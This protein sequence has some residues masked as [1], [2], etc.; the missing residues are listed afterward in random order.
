MSDLFEA[1]I[2]V[3]F[4]TSNKTDIVRKIRCN[5]NSQIKMTI[6]EY[7]KANNINLKKYYIYYNQTQIDE[8]KK[9]NEYGIKSGDNL[10]TSNKKLTFN[11]NYNNTFYSKSTDDIMNAS[12]NEN[13]PQYFIEKKSHFCYKCMKIIS[14]L[15]IVI[16]L[17]FICIFLF[18]IWKKNH[19]NN[20]RPINIFVNSTDAPSFIP[21]ETNSEIIHTST[22][23]IKSSLLNNQS[24]IPTNIPNV[25][26]SILYTQS[27]IP[28]TIPN[29]QSSALNNQSIIPINISNIQSSTLNTQSKIPATIPNMQ[30]SMLNTQTIIS[31]TYPNIQSSILNNQSIISTTIPNIQSSILNTQSTIST[32]Y[33]NIQSSILNS[34]SILISLPEST[35]AS[36]PLS[37]IDDIAITE[38]LVPEEKLAV[39]LNYK[40]NETMIFTQ[41]KINNSTQ[42]INDKQYNNITRSF[43]NFSVT[44]A[45]EFLEDNKKA[46]S[47]YLVILNMTNYKDNS[48]ELVANFDIFNNY[49]NVEIRNLNETIEK[50][51]DN[52]NEEEIINLSGKNFEDNNISEIYKIY[53]DKFNCSVDNESNSECDNLINSFQTFPVV[54]FTFFRNGEIKD[55]LLPKYLKSTIFFNM[56][57]LI[58]KIIPKINKD[59]YNKKKDKFWGLE[60]DEEITTYREIENFSDDGKQ[61]NLVEVEKSKVYADESS[62]EIKFEGSTSNS[63][64]I[65]KYNS[66][67]QMIENIN[68]KGKIALINDLPDEEDSTESNLLNNGIKSINLYTE[69]DIT[70]NKNII[71]S[72]IIDCLDDIF[73]KMEIIKYNESKYG[74]NTIRLLNSLSNNNVTVMKRD[75]NKIWSKIKLY[76]NKKAAHKELEMLRKLSSEA[77]MEFSY[78]Y[79]IFKTNIFGLKLQLQAIETFNV[80]KGKMQIQIILTVGC[81]DISYPITCFDSNINEIMKNT[82]TNTEKLI[83]L[84]NEANIINENLSHNFSNII[85]NYEEN[86]T[87]L[88]KDPFDFYNLYSKSLNDLYYSVENLTVD[89]LFD[90]IDLITICHDNYT[91]LLNRTKN[92]EEISINEIREVIINEY[93]SFINKMMEHLESFYNS[94]LIFLE[95]I[96]GLLTDN[97][98][99]DILYDIKDIIISTNNI[100]TKFGNLLFSSIQK[101]MEEFNY[102]LKNYI[103]SILGVL[104]ENSQFIAN[105]L[106]ENAI[107]RK[108]LSS[109]KREAIMT[110]LKNFKII[111]NEVVNYLYYKINDDYIINFENESKTNIKNIVKD[112]VLNYEMKFNEESGT[113]LSKIIRLINDIENYELYASNLN[114]IYNAGNNISESMFQGIYDDIMK[115]S[116]NKLNFV[117]SKELL[118]NKTIEIIDFINNDIKNINNYIHDYSFDYK[119][120]N[121]YKILSNLTRVNKYFKKSEM[122]NLMNEFYNLIKYSANKT[123]TETL[124]YNYN[125]SL[126]YLQS[127]YDYLWEKRNKDAKGVTYRFLDTTSNFVSN[128]ANLLSQIISE[129]P[130]MVKK[131]FLEI[132]NDIFKYFENKLSKIKKLNLNYTI[133]DDFIDLLNEEINT[134]KDNIKDY[135]NEEVFEREFLMNINNFTNE[136]AI[137][138]SDEYSKTY[139]TLYNKIMNLNDYPKA[140]SADSYHMWIVN[141][142]GIKTHR[143]MTQTS[144]YYSDMQKTFKNI[145]HINDFLE[146]ER[147]LFIRNFTDKFDEYINNYINLSKKFYDNLNIY[148]N[149]VLNNNTVLSKL[150]GEYRMIINNDLNKNSLLLFNKSDEIRDKLDG[151][152]N[153]IIYIINDIND[154]YLNN[155]YYKDKINYLEYPKEIQLRINIIKEEFIPLSNILKS[156][157]IQCYKNKIK[158]NFEFINNTTDIFIKNDLNN[159]FSE[160]YVNKIFNNYFNIKLNIINE[161]LSKIK[162][163]YSIYDYLN[164]SDL[165]DMDF[166]KNNN[167]TKNNLTGVINN[168]ES[169]IQ[170]DFSNLTFDSNYSKYNFNIVKLRNSI[171]YTKNLINLFENLD[172]DPQFNEKYLENKLNDITDFKIYNTYNKSL[173]KLN[174]LNRHSFDELEDYLTNFKNQMYPY[175]I[176]KTDDLNNLNNLKK[177][178]NNTIVIN[179][180]YQK[181]LDYKIDNIIKIIN[182]TLDKELTDL[183]I[184]GNYNFN[185]TE[186]QNYFDQ[187]LL[188]INRSFDILLNDTYKIGYYYKFTNSFLDEID[189]LY[190][191]K[192]FYF[193]DL[194]KSFV[195]SYEIKFFNFS[196]DLGENIEKYMKDLH[197]KDF[198]F[199]Y[200]YV[201]I[202]EEFLNK[203]NSEVYDKIQNLKKSTI[204]NIKDIFYNYTFNLNLTKCDYINEK[205]LEELDYNRTECANYTLDHLKDEEQIIYLSYENN[206]ILLNETINKGTNETDY[207]NICPFFNKT[208]YILYCYKNNYFN[209]NEYYY[210]TLINKNEIEN[211]STNLI[212][213]IEY[214][215]NSY[216]LT[217][218]L[219]NNSIDAYKNNLFL[220]NYS[221]NLSEISL[222]YELTDME[223]MS[224]F[225]L[226]NDKNE[227]FDFLKEELINEFN[228]TII[229]YINNIIIKDLELDINTKVQDLLNIKFDILENRLQNELNYYLHLL[230][231]TEKIGITTK[232]AFLNLYIDFNL[233]LD[234]N[235]NHIIDQIFYYFDIFNKKNTKLFIKD[236]YLYLKSD[237]G[238]KIFNLHENINAFIENPEFNSSLQEIVQINLFE[239]FERIKINMTN[240]IKIRMDLINQTLISFANILF[241]GINKTQVI[242]IPDMIPIINKTKE[243]NDIIKEQNYAFFF[244]VG[245][246]SYELF[247]YYIKMNL[248]PSLIEIKNKYD[249]IQNDMLNQIYKKVDENPDYSKLIEEKYQTDNVN[250]LIENYS[251]KIK[252]LINDYLIITK[253]NC[254]FIKNFKDLR[255][256]SEIKQYSHYKR[257]LSENISKNT[258]NIII[259][260]NTDNKVNNNIYDDKVRK[261]DNIFFGY[262]CFNDVVKELLKVNETINNFYEL[263]NGREIKY[264]NNTLINT[265]RKITIYTNNLQN[266][267]DNIIVKMSNIFTKEKLK[268]LNIQ[269]S[270]DFNSI[271]THVE[272]HKKNILFKINEFIYVVN[273]QSK[274]LLEQTKFMINDNIE[275]LYDKLLKNI[276]SRF[277]E[278]TFKITEQN[279]QSNKEIDLMDW[280]NPW[281]S[282]DSNIFKSSGIGIDFDAEEYMKAD[283]DDEKFINS[284]EEIMNNEDAT[285][286]ETRIP[287]PLFGLPFIIRIRIEFGFEFGITISTANHNL[288]SHLYA[289]AHSSVSAAGGLYLAAL[290]FGGGLRGLLGYGKV[291]IKPDFNLKYLTSEIVY[292]YKLATARFQVFAYFEMLFPKIYWIKVKFLFVSVRIP[293]IF[294]EMK[295]FEVG[296]KWTKGLQKENYGLKKN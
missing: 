42:I 225:L 269:I 35:I 30:S 68:S 173:E 292:Y 183:R 51:Y 128:S 59:L 88:I 172:I 75:E 182:D 69:S 36:I 76:N 289:E 12:E 123:I 291:G 184:K 264:L 4:K 219:Y 63:H 294:Y 41:I 187:I 129:F 261:L 258:S 5:L 210:D 236:F 235:I 146:K 95:D 65:R 244:K 44:I 280:D 22:Q 259:K 91:I 55:I 277:Q 124:D 262:L 240:D 193:G 178:L 45:E 198:N 194:I 98:Q 94:S 46:Y 67:S 109:D 101:G 18:L 114:K 121:K 192:S 213:T 245:N 206:C 199:I 216:I 7:I 278:K 243:F 73:S 229:E 266:Q 97:F 228:D 226:N 185:F 25:Q 175:I 212:N 37:V 38:P 6:D 153:D 239:I 218:C 249:E 257:R 186:Y 168:I 52:I 250:I 224:E 241:Y 209:K 197:E 8:T 103:T 253:N 105:S 85:I 196:L 71:N 9:F 50:I 189:T 86:V 159:I 166:D 176:N 215:L 180:I 28:T 201:D 171:Y 122:K 131:H 169:I 164:F 115:E 137:N 220:Y 273:N 106:N 191:E 112:K 260:N 145:E 174:I 286:W 27:I 84:L 125:I 272:N 17:A 152:F 43:T 58:G 242:Q 90:F 49:S 271:K 160:A 295:R 78:A 287:V 151:Y 140:E 211:L 283:N 148:I 247:N 141:I 227:Y 2:V 284:I 21:N 231:A 10:I 81:F 79:N 276:L 195:S 134:I 111:V 118:K 126:L 53:N 207:K 158:N 149:D 188:D 102:N 47:A 275:K 11:E 252:Y 165:I 285:L 19:K 26:S 147:I 82:Q 281:D 214:Y 127:V 293:I 270:K 93:F 33:K 234:K 119:R 157:F 24:I 163:N 296:S 223:I 15:F 23:D 274:L 282:K 246:K 290:E 167:L 57:D 89:T 83:D 39:D 217:E 132:Q 133:Y 265:N 279:F 143:T 117:F 40:L 62:K 16:L 31:Q 268:E 120:K 14:I 177:I 256:L 96:K 56:Y 254:D 233:E 32:T 77:I 205:Y 70:H 204:N 64:T 99:I 232:E 222:E 113:L 92:D 230:N 1:I 130:N 20:N 142:L 108:I 238:C 162:S 208:K 116:T 3:N 202:L 107:I 156:K 161:S 237:K 181:N 288:I 110:K 267:I 104:L 80:K 135:F 61:L 60:D 251:Q 200:E 221:I 179:E 74:N 138:I 29:I 66:E 203:K 255:E 34:Q 139:N 154:D 155:Y 100:F 54:K 248:E 87:N 170:N 150:I 72:N 263:F 13:N 48:S 190:K 136:K 144:M